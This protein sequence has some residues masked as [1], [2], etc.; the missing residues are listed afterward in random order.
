[1]HQ[2]V[3]QLLMVA[4]RRRAAVLVLAALAWLAW[5]AAAPGSLQQLDERSTDYVWQLTA[6]DTVER[7][8][9][10]VDIDD[11]SLARIGPWPWTRETMARLASALHAQR[12]GLQLCDVVFPHAR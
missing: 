5:I 6:N 9:V 1:M 3:G 12:A 2:W 7:R 10:L 4:W 11:Q 8:V